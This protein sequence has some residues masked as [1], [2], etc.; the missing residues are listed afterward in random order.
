MDAERLHLAL[1]AA[2]AGMYEVELASGRNWW[3]KEIWA[4]YGLAPGS[5]EPTAEA[6]L[7]TVDPAQRP[8]LV[9]KIDA[10]VAAATEFEAE[11]RVALP[12]AERWLMCR[13][14]PL[15]DVAGR[16]ER[17][18]GVVIDITRRVLAERAE[19]ERRATEH[20]IL[21]AVPLMIAAIG[22]DLRYRFVNRHYTECYGRPAA[23][24]VGRRV[25]EVIGAEAFE[26][27][28][29]NFERSFAGET[30]SF[31][32]VIRF[33]DGAQYRGRVTLV[34]ADG[35]RNGCFAVIRDVTTELAVAATRARL[36][37]EMET[38]A[39]QRVAQ[40]V[41]AALAHDLNQP[42]HAATVFVAAARRMLADGY[43]QTTIDATLERGGAELERAGAAV[44]LF[45][46]SS[47][48]PDLL[49]DM[50]VADLNAVALA[51]IERFREARQPLSTCVATG[52]A[53][54]S[55][56][57]AMHPMAIEKAVHNFLRNACV[58][59]GCGTGCTGSP[60]IRVRTA[61]VGAEALLRVEDDGP[62]V[63]AERLATLFEPQRDAMSTGTGVGLAI[64][65]ELVELHGGRIWH[66]PPPGGGAVFCF[67]LPLTEPA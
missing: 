33:A 12:D 65:R 49:P 28:A 22:R 25:P 57:A 56:P 64:T 58:A 37:E 32:N 51:A 54:G 11:W 34:P 26:R 27:V 45:A 50:V 52:F 60:R 10:A 15:L 8:A 38:L 29:A 59:I 4:L 16:P 30:T 66:E 2:D 20:A 35:G 19:A 14:R 47:A 40:F 1:E 67:T 23:W 17:Y 39:R 62:G 31:D 7:A 48:Q 53:D 42:L 24:I 46:V 41:A 55:L 13:G 43:C 63:A 36:G 6:F 3:S 5:V 61:R 9:A 18:I 21:D 44:R